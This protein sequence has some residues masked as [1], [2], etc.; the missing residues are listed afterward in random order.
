MSYEH[1]YK[2]EYPRNLYIA[3]NIE[4]EMP[5]NA[6]RIVEGVLTGTYFTDTERKFVKQR[7][8]NCMT[9]QEIAEEN[10]ISREASRQRQQ[11]VL[12]KLFLYKSELTGETGVSPEDSLTF[13]I[14]M[15]DGYLRYRTKN[16]LRRAG[17][18]CVGDIMGM[19]VKQLLRIR[20]IWIGTLDEIVNALSHYGIRLNGTDEYLEQRK[21]MGTRTYFTKKIT[22]R[23]GNDT[24]KKTD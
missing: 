21:A 23:H 8:E 5:R 2:T 4:N 16:M 1:F 18:I 24:G 14:M 22:R 20:G 17:L 7:F 12:T 9:L 10:R 13:D 6:R 3:L 15:R 19:S 11:K